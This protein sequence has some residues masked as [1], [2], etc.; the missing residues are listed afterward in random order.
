MNI[1]LTII[2]SN[3]LHRR[4]IFFLRQE[5]VIMFGMMGMDPSESLLE[6][7]CPDSFDAVMDPE[8]DTDPDDEEEG[9]EDEAE[10]RG[11]GATSWT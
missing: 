3:L 7:M 2:T 5:K 8:S 10:F 11:G 9:K 6:M 1:R 4:I